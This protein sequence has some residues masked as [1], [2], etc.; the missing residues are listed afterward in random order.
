LHIT[1]TAMD[2]TIQSHKSHRRLKAMVSGS[3]LYLT[4]AV[5]ETGRQ[6]LINELLLLRRE[7]KML[8]E[9]LVRAREETET[10]ARRYKEIFDSAPVGYLMLDC[11][12]LI[13]ELNST[14]SNLFAAGKEFLIEKPLKLFVD[15]DF[16]EVY[17]KLYQYV[18][19]TGQPRACG[20]K[21]LREDGSSFHAALKCSSLSDAE[22]NDT[23]LLAA[24]SDITTRVTTQEKLQETSMVLKVILKQREEDRLEMESNVFSNINKLIVPYIDKLSQ[25]HLREDQAKYLK[26]IQTNLENI[27]SSFVKQLLNQYE[28]FTPREIEIANLIKY[29]RKTKDIADLLSISRRSVEFHK[30][31]IRRKI[32]LRNKKMNLQAFLISFNPSSRRISS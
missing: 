14:A 8:N 17:D 22:H 10:V 11:E 32:G 1:L 15:K 21:L 23:R 31:N 12:G 20:L 3:S 30:N 24:I 7:L 19:E 16:H 29:G 5:S 26:F 2:K 25:T 4:R 27:V 28:D 18:Y 6:T 13:R 9:Q